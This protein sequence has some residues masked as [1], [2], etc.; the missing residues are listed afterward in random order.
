MKRIIISLI[1]ASLAL[2]SAFALSGCGSQ[3]SSS[4]KSEAK[5]EASADASKGDSQ[6]GAIPASAVWTCEDGERYAWRVSRSDEFPESTFVVN[7]VPV[8]VDHEANAVLHEI[9]VLRR[10]IITST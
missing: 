6:S 3:S 5:S 2:T 8:A 4:S 10:I 1:A 7:A 9:P